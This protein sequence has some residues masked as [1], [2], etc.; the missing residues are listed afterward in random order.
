MNV[1][2]RIL[3]VWVLSGV[4]LLAADFW[5]EKDFTT[6]SDKEVE[7]MLTDS[8]WAKRVAVSI[9]GPGSGGGFSP[10]S[11]EENYQR[12]SAARDG[13]ARAGDDNI[14]GRG[15]GDGFADGAPRVVLTVFWRSALPIKQALVRSQAG[16]DAPV[17]PAQR[18]FL[19]QQEPLYVVSI[20]GIPTPFGEGLDREA[21]L[22]RT[23][24]E[25]DDADPIAAEDVE[26]FLV[27]DGTFILEF[28][29]LRDDP[30]TLLDRNVEFV[31]ELGEVEIKRSFSVQ[32]MMF[33]DA[34][35][36]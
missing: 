7:K 23:T 25:R 4:A 22:E 2:V 5:E 30:V 27:D 8:P 18:P 32:E 28:A 15:R 36:M 34:L 16:I 1:T 3:G 35:A 33:G 11:R 14:R 10:F 13:R 20:S 24:L 19:I 29:F 31:T 21:L 17:P 26:P 9:G 6:W 12:A